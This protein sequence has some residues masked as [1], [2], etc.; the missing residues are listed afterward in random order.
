VLAGES[1]SPF[2]FA[3]GRF[4]G[5]LVCLGACPELVER[6]RLSFRLIQIKFFS[7]PTFTADEA[8]TDLNRPAFDRSRDCGKTSDLYQGTTLRGRT[9][10]RT[11]RA[12]APAMAH[13]AQTAGS[14]ATAETLKEKASQYEGHGFSRAVNGRRLTASA[15]EVRFSRLTGRSYHRSSGL[16]I[17]H[18][19][20]P[21]QPRLREAL[22]RFGTMEEHRVDAS[23]VD[24]RTTN[25]GCT[26]TCW[27]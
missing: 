2:E 16:P 14:G 12:L 10:I 3:P 26:I 20:R 19:L 27:A 21:L 23:A 8:F 1:L 24:S 9:R 25:S 22:F 13:S 4:V 17:S 7:W 15:A 5:Y 11:R 18:S 6:V